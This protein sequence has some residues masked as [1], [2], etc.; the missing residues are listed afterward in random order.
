MKIKIS[1][2]IILFWAIYTLLYISV[3]FYCKNTL[4]ETQN[5]LLIFCVILV[6]LFKYKKIKILHRKTYIYCIM[7]CI[8]LISGI[9]AGETYKLII[10]SIIMMSLAAVFADTVEF[11]N[12]K[13]EFVNVL[14]VVSIF[15]T[16]TWILYKTSP[17]T[18]EIFPKIYSSSGVVTY[19]L[20]FVILTPRAFLRSEGFF[21]EPGVFQTF[22]NIAIMFLISKRDLEGKDKRKLLVL[23][24]A[25]IL[26]FS[27]T[28]YI[29]GIINLFLYLCRKY[30]GTI[31]RLLKVI[32]IVII[33]FLTLGILTPILPE[34]INGVD[35][36][37]NKVK[38]FFEGSS[39]T[40]IDSSSVRYDSVVYP[41]KSFLYNP[42]FGV[43]DIG[44][45]RLYIMMGHNMLT[46]TIVNYFAMY[47]GL[48]GSIVIYLFYSLSNKLITYKFLSFICLVIFLLSTFSENY[49]NYFIINVF[50]MYGAID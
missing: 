1:N 25:L 31:N 45:K 16:L 49:V 38:K 15:S 11:K 13:D 28:G 8:S 20:F 9:L 32:I 2:R 42:L 36:G 22:L 19:N 17:N 37:V 44:L 43:S 18:F 39:S 24:I 14:Y 6:L 40:M 4:T 29:V 27:T 34:T 10:Y 41:L 48:Y 50:L 3:G 26:T 47:G 7:L 46:C 23:F 12:F 21:W 30:N 35:F 33:F 5:I